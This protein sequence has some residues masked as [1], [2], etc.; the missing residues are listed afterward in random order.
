M[1]DQLCLNLIDFL[2][3]FVSDNKAQPKYSI[4]TTGL[5]ESDDI[6]ISQKDN[7]FVLCTKNDPTTI[8]L[9]LNENVERLISSQCGNV[10]ILKKKK[11]HS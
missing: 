11:N 10:K 6:V 7:T 2:F 4:S 1:V 9:G 8:Q 5:L 3:V